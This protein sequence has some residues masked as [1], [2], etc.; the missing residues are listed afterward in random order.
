VFLR[1]RRAG[2]ARRQIVADVDQP[3]NAGRRCSLQHL[4]AIGVKRIDM[5]MGMRVDQ[6][7]M[8]ILP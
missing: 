6:W 4:G 3:G 2:V 5:N 7:H 8:G 1:Q